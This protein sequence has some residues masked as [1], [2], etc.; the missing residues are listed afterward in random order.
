MALLGRYGPLAYAAG[1]GASRAYT[2]FSNFAGNSLAQQVTMSSY[3]A[4][5]MST[6][7]GSGR[8]AQQAILNQAFGSNAMATGVT[9]AATGQSILNAVSGFTAGA[10]PGYAQPLARG[11][12]SYNALLNY[13]NGLSYTQSAGITASL[14]S[15]QT[16]MNFYMMGLGKSSPLQLGGKVNS[17]AAGM[18]ESL[19]QRLA[20]GENLNQLR[21]NMRSGGVLSSEL[22]QLTGLSGQNLEAFITSG[23]DV[24][25]LQSEGLS[26]S[27]INQLMQQAG[28]GNRGAQQQL[29]KY[30]VN[31]TDLQAQKDVTAT[32]TSRQATL[33]QSFA[34]GLDQASKNLVAFNDAMNKLLQNPLINQATG[35]ASGYKAEASKQGSVRQSILGSGVLSTHNAVGRT[36]N[37]IT[38][39]FSGFFGALLGGGATTPGQKQHKQ[40]AGQ[41]GKNTNTAGG[42][43]KQAGAAVHAAETQLGV[44][45]QWGGENPGRGFDCS[46]LIQ[47]AYGQAGV[48]L[49]RTSQAQ[50]SFLR[51]FQVPL[52]KV[53]EGDIVFS[54][55]SDGTASAP[56]HEA[57]M[58]SQKQLIQAPFTGQNVQIDPF[59]ASQWLFAAR[60]TGSRN[61]SS[62]GGGSPNGGGTSNSGNQGNAGAAA[63]SPGIGLDPGSYGS[64]D[65]LSTVQGALLGGISVSAPA[66]SSSGGNSQSPGSGGTGSGGAGGSSG[67]K[68]GT[69]KANQAIA[70]KLM[71]SYGWTSDAEWNALVSLWNRESGWSQTAD[72][73]VTGLDPK[74]A[75]VFAYGVAQ[76]RPWSK[77]PRA[78]WPPDKGGQ[79]NAGVQITWGMN[80]IRDSDYK[81]PI[82]AWAHEQAIGWYGTGTPAARKGYA[83]VGDRGPELIKLTGGEKILNASQSAHLA[84][85]DAK[86]PMSHPYKNLLS[87]NFSLPD[88]PV[89]PAA[90]AAAGKTAAGG[91]NITFGQGSIMLGSGVTAQDAKNFVAAVAD[92]TRHNT[93][94]TAIANGALHG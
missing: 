76:A 80:Y 74:D 13:P 86:S 67:A 77:Y 47:W 42:I 16:A 53:Q 41:S 32:K 2:A 56:G 59:D 29:Q 14:M 5:Q 88:I 28:K 90:A 24:A 85:Q 21:Y 69:P 72:T 35:Y 78:G 9:D 3:L 68:G 6:T 48:A 1:Y 64:A 81:D 26:S 62:P 92:A 66:V 27:K 87:G 18:Y 37:T 52:D 8:A 51:K 79:A 84:R 10:V 23:L 73:R 61:G 46:G 94:M 55:G 31:L 89:S 7:S 57:L 43:S 75:K 82:H 71:K 63:P 93:T 60:P 17:N 15:P 4:Q 58:V 22:G 44:P 38:G 34:S 45:Y 49:P 11:A 65:E 20:P 40:A 30:G 83:V 39:G 19:F 70:K 33:E 25:K 50:W 54:A 91:V 36:I 12:G